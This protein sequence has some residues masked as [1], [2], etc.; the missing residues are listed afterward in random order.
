MSFITTLQA[1]LVCRQ[2]PPPIASYGCNEPLAGSNFWRSDMIA[3]S[4]WLG[5]ILGRQLIEQD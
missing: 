1:P 4:H 5:A 3:T 2:E